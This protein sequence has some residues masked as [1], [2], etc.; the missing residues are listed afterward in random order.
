MNNSIDDI[1]ARAEK[2]NA[3]VQKAVRKLIERKAALNGSLVVGD[4]DGFKT[5]PAKDLLRDLNEKDAKK[6]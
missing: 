4:I 5:V 3:G 6:A 2:I 1:F